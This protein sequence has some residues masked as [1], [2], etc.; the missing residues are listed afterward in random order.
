MWGC[1]KRVIHFSKDDG[2]DALSRIGK[3]QPNQD[4]LTCGLRRRSGTFSID[5]GTASPRVAPEDTHG[6]PTSVLAFIYRGE[7]A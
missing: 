3:G 1:L 5:V 2:D 7:R 4:G 6:A